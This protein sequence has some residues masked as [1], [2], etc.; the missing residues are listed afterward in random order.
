MADDMFVRCSAPKNVDDPREHL[1]ALTEAVV[2]DTLDYIRNIG[3]DAQ[4]H[5]RAILASGQ[6]TRAA[7]RR[8]KWGAKRR[9]SRWSRMREMWGLTCR[10]VGD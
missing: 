3:G 5:K 7:L 6:D 1:I 10:V 4:L 9:P 2:E 8:L